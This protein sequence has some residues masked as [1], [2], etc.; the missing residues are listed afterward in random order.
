MK[1]LTLARVLGA[2]LCPLAVLAG[3][4]GSA[5]TAGQPMTSP[6]LSTVRANSLTPISFA[7][8]NL[9]AMIRPPVHLLARG[10]GWLSP[11]AR[12]C[13][14]KL[15]ASSFWLDYVSI[16]CA[17]KGRHNQPPIGQITDG[18]SGPEGEIADLFTVTSRAYLNASVY[19][20]KGTAEFAKLYGGEH[21]PEQFEAW[22]DARAET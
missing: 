1:N 22:E 8:A 20:Q 12:K 7:P 21:T 17:K 10:S 13:K 9:R 4:S 18:I 6:A 19:D 5:S 15:F 11:A 14:Q 2:S 16:Y 3:C